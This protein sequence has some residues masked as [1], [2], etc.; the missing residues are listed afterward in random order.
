MTEGSGGELGLGSST[1]TLDH[2]ESRPKDRRTSPFKT[3]ISILSLGR[4]EDGRVD[5]N[6]WQIIKAEAGDGSV[7]K[8][9]ASRA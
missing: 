1:T 5:S 6:G 3:V 7:D 8:A 2:L 9:L 4:V